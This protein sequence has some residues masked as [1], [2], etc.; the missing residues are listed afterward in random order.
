MPS[1]IERNHVEFRTKNLRDRSPG[2]CAE[3]V[4]MGKDCQRFIGMPIKTCDVD[5]VVE[6]P[7]PVYGFGNL[8]RV[9]PISNNKFTY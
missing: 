7:C 4:G 9:S 6:V 3:S 8:Y 5:V 1:C 2:G